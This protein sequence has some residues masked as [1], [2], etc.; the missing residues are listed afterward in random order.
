[1]KKHTIL[2]IDADEQYS[3]LMVEY[4]EEEGFS[5][6]RAE[7]SDVALK[8][9]AVEK[10]DLI[11]LDIMMPSGKGMDVCR[12]LK[13]TPSTS[14]IPI[15]IV[16]GSES[17]NDK[18]SGYLTG[19]MEWLAKP[20]ELGELGECVRNVLWQSNCYNRQADNNFEKRMAQGD[21]SS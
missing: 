21:K 12:T 8:H 20:F 5:A 2:V 10:P 13:T 1:M 19:A 17:L 9:I 6:L 3:E 14:A 15:V 4:L 11:L 7:D 16:T 18:L